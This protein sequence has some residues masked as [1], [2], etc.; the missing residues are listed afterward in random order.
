MKKFFGLVLI[1][2]FVVEFGAFA[3]VGPTSAQT[4]SWDF[5][6]HTHTHPWLDQLTDDEI[7]AQYEMVNDAFTAHGLATPEHTAYPGGRTDHKGRVKGITAEYRLSGR[8]VWGYMSTFPIEDWYTLR[9]AQL[10]SNTKISDIQGWI[11]DCVADNA[12]LV[13]LTHDVKAVPTSYGCTPEKLHQSLDYALGKENAGLL[14]VVTLTDAYDYWSTAQEGKAMVVFTFDDCWWT[15]YDNVYPMFKDH[16]VA[17]TSYIIT[18]AIENVEWDDTEDR[19]TWA[20][21]DDMVN[22]V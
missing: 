6:C 8:V 16:G 21:I 14:E 9:A 7:R 4:L 2:V 1:V 18:A 19:L 20:M 5:Q 12:L 22:W 10:K 3:A 17:G 15:D 13:I 11:D